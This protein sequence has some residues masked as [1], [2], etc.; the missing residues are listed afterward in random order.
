MVEQLQMSSLIAMF[1]GHIASAK[2]TPKTQSPSV[3]HNSSAGGGAF[4]S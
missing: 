2:G 3:L 4:N 1:R